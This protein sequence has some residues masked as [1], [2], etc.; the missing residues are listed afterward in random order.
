MSNT[1]ANPSGAIAADVN[2]TGRETVVPLFEEEVNVA[3]RIVETGRVQVS[4]ITHSH[5]HMVDELLRHEKVEVE[6]I[7]MERPID[8]M[9]SIRQEG[10]V[11]IVPVVEEVLK[12]ERRLVLREEVHIRRVQ[13]TER[14]QKEVTLR[15]QEALISRL[16]P[17]EPV[18]ADDRGSTQTH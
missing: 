18:V 14:Y 1:P 8:A 11:T 4:R 15:K 9:P 13:Q 2:N 3:K 17:E 6:R 12:I 7:P 10:D 16:A 5:Q